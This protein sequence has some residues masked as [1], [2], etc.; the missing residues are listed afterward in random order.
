M[1]GCNVEKSIFILIL[2]TIAGFAV[3]M[4]SYRRASEMGYGCRERMYHVE[5][6]KQLALEVATILVCVAVVAVGFGYAWAY[7]VFAG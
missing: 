1:E 4:C 2:V 3:W 6:R 5:A 7:T